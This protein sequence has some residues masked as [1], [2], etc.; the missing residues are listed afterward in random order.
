MIHILGGVLV[1]IDARGRARSRD[2]P[3]CAAT[4]GPVLPPARIFGKRPPDAANLCADC[5]DLVGL[6]VES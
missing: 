3:E 4:S 1:S 2:L 5:A 6:E